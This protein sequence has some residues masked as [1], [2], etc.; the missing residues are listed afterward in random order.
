MEWWLHDAG[1]LGKRLA[2]FHTWF[3]LLVLQGRGTLAKRQDFSSQFVIYNGRRQ[4]GQAPLASGERPAL[5]PWSPVCVLLVNTGFPPLGRRVAPFKRGLGWVA[6]ATSPQ[7][8]D[9]LRSHQ[10]RNRRCQVH[11]QTKIQSERPWKQTSLALSEA[12]C[13]LVAAKF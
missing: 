3:L 9:D 6:L 13:Q 7:S 1:V 12:K 8:L 5:C 11:I 4:F 2:C 10:H